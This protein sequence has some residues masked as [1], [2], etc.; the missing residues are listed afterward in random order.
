MSYTA[1][2]L[3]APPAASF[4]LHASGLSVDDR[5]LGVTTVVAYAVASSPAVQEAIL[6]HHVLVLMLVAQFGL[7]IAL[8]AAVHKMSGG[9][10][11]G[12][13]LLTRPLRAQRFRPFCGLP[14][15]SIANA[16]W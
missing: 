1:V 15:A 10:A 8:S 5:R 13:F 16:F 2:L 6:Q 7:V 3:K 9:T 14:I 12:L 11:T 4:H